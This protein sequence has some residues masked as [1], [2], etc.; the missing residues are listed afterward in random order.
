MPLQFPRQP[1][2]W[3][4]FVVFT[5]AACSPPAAWEPPGGTIPIPPGPPGSGPSDDDTFAQLTAELDLIPRKVLFG[6]PDRM[7][8]QLSP[9][10]QWLSF[11]A[12]DE[13]VMN[14]WVAPS[15]QPEKATVITADR[16]RGIRRY[17]WAYDNQ[18][19]LYLQDKG[20]DENWRVY[21]VDVETKAEIDL[22]PLEGVRAQIQEVSPKFPGAVLIGLNDRDPKYHD[23]HRV[24]IASGKRQLVLEND[25][26]FGDVTTDDDFRVR[27]AGK[28]LDDGGEQIFQHDGKG[29]FAPWVRISSEDAL[30]T[31]ILGFN[32]KG[33]AVYMKDSRTRDKAALTRTALTAAAP[34]AVVIAGDDKADLARVMRHPRDKTVQAVAAV[35][36]RT[37]WQFL[38][39]DVEADFARLAQVARGDVEVVS[40][41]LNDDKWIVVLS[42]DDGPAP[43]YLFDRTTKE[44]KL[45]FVNREALVGLELQRMKP[46]VIRAR[47][48]LE[49]VSYL[50]LPRGV[51]VQ[52][53]KPAEAQP[54]VLLV[55]GGPWARDRWGYNS[56]HQWLANRGYAVLSVNYRGSIGFGKAFINAGD[57]QWARTM[58]DDLIDAVSWAVNAGIAQP[59][60]VA[61]MGGS[62]GGYA[63]LVGLTMT[64][65]TF[66]CG[67]DIVGPSNLVTLLESIPPYWAPYL[68]LFAKRV[69]DHQTEEGRALLRERSPL[70]YVDRIVK[71]LLIGQG[72]NDPRVKQAES[73][74]IVAAMTKRNIPVTYVL[75]P[76]EGHGFRRPE[77]MTA[78]QAV[79]EAFLAGC[80]GGGAEPIGT[81]FAGAS[82]Q[83]PTGAEHV[84]GVKAALSAAR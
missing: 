33:D 24:E 67:V 47:D 83:I 41:T 61:I 39:K 13:G 21:S 81:D 44:A 7:G 65:E 49:L 27:F 71:P 48:G 50:S 30:T 14:V 74:Q 80:L 59:D 38:D 22:T 77:N 1:I 37:K 31:G 9:D 78:F 23:I 10:G 8:A 56:M 63:T 15:A 6:N 5:L 3:F 60:K 25:R 72:A 57:K 35:H 18:H 64:P 17:F 29:G 45:L 42:T 2:A 19:I 11:L 68:A 54:M 58:H 43:Y 20:G 36:T 32:A 79:A 70:S 12:P 52:D 66:A 55:H 53:G 16:K 73:D 51:A 40:R 76:D 28:P 34:E 4:A 69:G 75:F 84:P 46:V 62:Y 82:I 26:G